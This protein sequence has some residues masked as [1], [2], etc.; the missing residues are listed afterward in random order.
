ME[1]VEILERAEKL[2]QMVKQSEDFELYHINKKIM[3][4]DPLTIE[5]LRKFNAMKDNYED[6]QR[7]GRYHPDYTAI[8]KEVRTIKRR[9]EEHTSE[10]QSRG[11]L[12]CRLL[13]EKK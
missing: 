9:S 8:M 1:V 5:L 3:Y 6:V 13:L 12:V 10:L 2:G 11:H 7:F 4:E